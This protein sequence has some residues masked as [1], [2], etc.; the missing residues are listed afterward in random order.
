MPWERCQILGIR[1]EKEALESAF[2]EEFFTLFPNSKCLPA[3]LGIKIFSM[4][5]LP[6]PLHC[7]GVCVSSICMGNIKA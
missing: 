2:H 6:H 3:N 4:T 7:T 1:V 5:H